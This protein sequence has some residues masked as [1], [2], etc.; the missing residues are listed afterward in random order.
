MLAVDEKR[1][2]PASGVVECLLQVLMAEPEPVTVPTSTTSAMMAPPSAV[3][4]TAT[5]VSFAAVNA[6]LVARW[7]RSLM[8]SSAGV[9]LVV[10]DPLLGHVGR[11][12]GAGRVE[13]VDR[14]MVEVVGG[15]V[16]GH[17]VALWADDLHGEVLRH[18]DAAAG[19]VVLDPVAVV[20]GALTGREAQ[21]V[22]LARDPR[23]DLVEPRAARGAPAAVHVGRVLQGLLTADLVLHDVVDLLQRQ[24]VLRRRPERESR[25]RRS[26]DDGRQQRQQEEQAGPPADEVPHTRN[27]LV[28]GAPDG[29]ACPLDGLRGGSPI[30]GSLPDRTPLPS[31]RPARSP[32]AGSMK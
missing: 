28:R 30:H 13:R 11:V 32:Y 26:D 21:V 23:L 1:I 4:A 17:R 9:P 15:R 6:E 29:R 5:G 18:P 25:Q 7:Q 20:A 31:A 12:V 24:R 10:H 19:V 8:A 2:L 14:R 16:A 3:S 22:Q 27:P